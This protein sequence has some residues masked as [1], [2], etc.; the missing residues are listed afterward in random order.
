MLQYVVYNSALSDIS[1]TE[2]AMLSGTTP[3]ASIVPPPYSNCIVVVHQYV[4][5]M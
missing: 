5:I 2:R 4:D 3:R 1:K